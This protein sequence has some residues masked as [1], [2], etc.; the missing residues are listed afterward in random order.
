MAQAELGSTRFRFSVLKPGDQANGTVE[1]AIIAETPIAIEFNGIGYA[2]MMA[3][4]LDLNDFAIGFSLAEGLID[5]PHQIFSI[6][7]QPTAQ[8][9]ILRVQLPPDKAQRVID[10][11]R[12]RVSESSC[13]LCGMD[14][15]DE[16]MRPLP[17]VSATMDLQKAAIFSALNDLRAHQPLS[18]A[19]GTSHAAAFCAPD[20]RILMVRE[21]VGRHNALDKLIG[22]LAANAIAAS[23]GFIVLTARCSFELVQKTILANCPALVTISA[24]TDLAIATAAKHNLTLVSLARPDEALVDGGIGVELQIR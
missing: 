20:G 6:D 15:L 12:Q 17:Q 2:V 14:N 3:T 9:W 13:G 10:R 24:A 1:R 7:S 21:D 8:G 5:A 18:V 19:T 11:A 22:A 23:S 16:V 4:P